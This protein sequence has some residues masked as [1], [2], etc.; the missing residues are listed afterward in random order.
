MPPTRRSFVAISAL[1]LA[2]L[3]FVARPFAQDSKSSEK[4]APITIVLVRH[5]EKGTDDPRDPSLSEAGRARAERL[6]KMLAKSGVGHVYASEFKRTRETVAPFASAAKLDVEVVSAGKPDELVA[7]LRALAPGSKA[8]VAGHSNTVPK[9]AE[10]LGVELAGLEKGPAGDQFPDA[11][12]GRV[13]VLTLPTAPDA[14]ASVVELA[15]GD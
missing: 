5:A 10:L 13:V 2:A 4:L 3:A 9:L 15:M 8:L 6:A 7:K 14:A 11:E 12:Y 1:A